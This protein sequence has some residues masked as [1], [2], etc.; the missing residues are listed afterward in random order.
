MKNDKIRFLI[1]KK[2]K[3]KTKVETLLRQTELYNQKNTLAKN[4]S[5]GQKRK[6]CV[7]IALI[8]DPQVSFPLIEIQK[9]ND[10]FTDSKINYFFR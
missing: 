8:G 9:R 4:L 6:L 5:G 1:L 3:T 10:V 7:A 2:I